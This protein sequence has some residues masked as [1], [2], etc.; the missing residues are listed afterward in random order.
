MG[1]FNKK[2]DENA[3]AEIIEL[4]TEG[5]DH[6]GEAYESLRSAASLMRENPDLGPEYNI[7]GNMEGY[8]LNYI[9]GSSDSLMNKVEV[10]IEEIETGKEVS[11]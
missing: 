9:S 6:L 2:A 8:V 10:Y 3:K 4:L 7:V 11:E 5:A 1:W